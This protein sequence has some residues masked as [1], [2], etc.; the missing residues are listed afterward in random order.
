MWVGDEV[1][2]GATTKRTP[3]P[4]VLCVSSCG[5]S[6]SLKNWH[7]LSPASFPCPAGGLL[8]HNPEGNVGVLKGVA[9]VPNAVKR[10]TRSSC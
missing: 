7:I 3:L 9:F 6:Q 10:R 4:P 5:D 8:L 1:T 2:G